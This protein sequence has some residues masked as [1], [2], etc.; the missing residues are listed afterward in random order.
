MIEKTAGQIA[1]E[2]F[3]ERCRFGP[4]WE[5][6]E[7]GQ[8]QWEEVAAAVSDHVSSPLLK[9]IEELEAEVVHWR[10][11]ADDHKYRGSAEC[12]VNNRKF[13]PPSPDMVEAMKTAAEWHGGDF[14]DGE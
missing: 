3:M 9:R 4:D 5:F 2:K 14:E 10:R 11:K 8:T 6:L 13:N 12:L 1:Y 7:E